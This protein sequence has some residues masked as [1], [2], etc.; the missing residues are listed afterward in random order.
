[1]RADRAA[2]EPLGRGGQA[3]AGEEDFLAAQ[4]PAWAELA[5]SR[6]RD[7]CREK[8][9]RLGILAGRRRMKAKAED[10]QTAGRTA[11]APSRY[12]PLPSS[13]CLKGT[14]PLPRGLGPV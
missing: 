3:Q 9:V 10:D 4:D 11:I 13:F 8:L 7:E 6:E 12:S 2:D 5:R 14:H 1:M